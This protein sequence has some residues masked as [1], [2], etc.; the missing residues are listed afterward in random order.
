MSKQR[1]ALLEVTTLSPWQ[2]LVL[3]MCFVVGGIWLGQ[4]IASLCNYVNTVVTHAMAYAPFTTRTKLL[5]LQVAT[6][7]SAFIVAPI[8]YLQW[9]HQRSVRDLFQWKQSYTAPMLTLLGLTIVFMIVNTRLIQWNM[10]IRLPAW[11]R[12]FEIWVQARETT[13]QETTHLSTTFHALKDLF[14]GIL[15][16]GVMPAIGEELLFRGLVQPILHMLTHNI[17][18]A[19]M[20]GALGFSIMHCQFYS[21][22]PRFLLG[23]LFG[24]VYYWTKDL[25]FP[26]AAHFVN[27]T[28]T[29][30]IFFCQQQQL[31]VQNV[32]PTHMLPHFLWICLVGLTIVL[33]RRLRQ[34]GKQAISQGHHALQHTWP[35]Q[36][37][38][39]TC[40]ATPHDHY[41][42]V[43]S[44]NTASHESPNKLRKDESK[45]VNNTPCI[46]N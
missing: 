33:A 2:H 38:T 41:T 12:E 32:A 29:L 42:R 45:T 30:V 16:I 24:Y 17:H 18:W 35:R 43:A 25:W 27:N 28:L 36:E 11:L 14:I 21:L 37:R 46:K 31:I 26:I 40:R 19:I 10:T 13:L 23:A 15:V 7:S 1:I 8:L 3:L 5:V 44:L 34:L 22:L 9:V 4:A 39:L 6:T 20:I